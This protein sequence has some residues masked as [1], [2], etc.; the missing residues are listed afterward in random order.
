MVTSLSADEASRQGAAHVAYMAAPS[1][2]LSRAIDAD[3]RQWEA[4]GRPDD[5]EGDDWWAGYTKP[6]G[7]ADHWNNR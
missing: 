1:R 7:A 2:V 5:D 4:D 3:I 6:A